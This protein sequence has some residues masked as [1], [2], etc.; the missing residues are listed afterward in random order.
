MTGKRYGRNRNSKGKGF[1]ARYDKTRDGKPLFCWD[2][3]GKRV[4]KG[5]M[6]HSN[7]RGAGYLHKACAHKL[8]DDPNAFSKPKPQEEPQDSTDVENETTPNSP[9]MK[10]AKGRKGRGEPKAPTLE[11]AGKLGVLNIAGRDFTVARKFAGL[12]LSS[13]QLNICSE[14]IGGTRNVQVIAGPGCGKSFI[15]TLLSWLFQAQGLSG[16]YI[17]FGNVTV[18]E[19]R[20][21]GD[22]A[23]SF[24]CST[25]HS[26][27]QR[28]IAAS[29]PGS[30]KVKLEQSKVTD[31]CKGIW[32]VSRYV[33]RDV[34]SQRW[35]NIK[36]ARK[37]VS[38][39]KSQLKSTPEDG[40]ALMQKFQIIGNGANV[41]E[42]LN[43]I[44]NILEECKEQ[45]RLGIIDFDDMI[46][47]PLVLG[48]KPRPRP[49]VFVDEAQDFSPAQLQLALSIAGQ[50]GRTFMVGD[51]RQAIYRWRGAA[52]HGM[53]DALTVLRAHK[54]GA[55]RM[56][57]METRRCSK[58]SVALCNMLYPYS[59]D[60][61]NL[62]AH[63][64]NHDGVFVKV[65]AGSDWLS[66]GPQG[67][68]PGTGCPQGDHRGDQAAQ[69][70][71][72]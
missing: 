34:K 43:N 69:P 26:E 27:G 3:C 19:M 15:L 32:D 45:A 44:P 54:L 30:T 64:S 47:A 11:K 23:P 57:L 12:T 21:A 62:V 29:L 70:L 63:G 51:M 67:G 5:Q 48:L 35:H 24:S 22:L 46:W 16:T 53:D 59:T 9:A 38:L 8:I 58:A 28:I 1:A 4:E 55:K 60:V 31:I 18:N 68:D 40:K 14:A 52:A 39:Y 37:L 13:P 20:E 56:P 61:E 36:L 25:S 49:V 41:G 2:G 71:G 33:G 65:M 66:A 10:V 17:A 50:A 42:V 72:Q 7:P 6:I